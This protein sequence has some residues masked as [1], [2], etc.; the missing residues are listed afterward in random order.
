MNI[1]LNIDWQQ[2]LLHMLNLTVLVTGLTLLLFKPV[3]DFMDKRRKYYLDLEKANAEREKAAL[4]KEAEYSKLIENAAAELES[5][6]AEALHGIELKRVQTEEAA[7]AQA[8][9]IIADAVAE[10]NM[11]KSKIADMTKDEIRVLVVKAAEKLLAEE[12][13]P[14]TDARLYDRF[15]KESSREEN[16]DKE[17]GN[18]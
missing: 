4:E 3:K 8:D 11:Q 6:K 15:L 1:P 9:K 7:R 18:E 5:M 16:E 14:E 10:A 2:I 12:S 13:G 17:N